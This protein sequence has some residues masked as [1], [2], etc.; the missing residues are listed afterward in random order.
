[1]KGSR[2]EE[3]VS[4]AREAVWDYHRRCFR[5]WREARDRLEQECHL[6]V[7]PF[8]GPDRRGEEPHL[9]HGM[10][11]LLYRRQFAI[12]VAPQLEQEPW[13]RWLVDQNDQ[14]V[15]QADAI[16][17]ACGGPASHDAVQRGVAALLSRMLDPWRM[18]AAELIKLHHDLQYLEGIFREALGAV[19]ESEVRSGICPEC[20]YPERG[21]E[22]TGEVY[23]S[24]R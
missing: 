14:A 1:M 17:V 16:S 21:D 23:Q 24:L 22:E 10:V 19:P 8:L 6:P 5:L 2:A 12:S 15:L 11:D 18:R 9:F 13:P 20:P 7:R 4:A 3:V